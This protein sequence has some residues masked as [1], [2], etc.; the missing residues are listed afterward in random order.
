MSSRRPAALL[1]LL[2]LLLVLGACAGREEEEP[3]AQTAPVL[4]ELV[5]PEAQVGSTYSASLAASGGAAPL[6]YVIE[7][8]PPGLTY[9]ASTGALLGRATQ[10]GAFELSAK[11]V[12]ARGAQDVQAYALK[13]IASLQVTT[14]S[15]PVGQVGAA[16]RTQLAVA[17]PAQAPVQWSVVEGALPAGLALSQ[18]GVLSGTPSA[19]GTASFAVQARDAAGALGQRALLLEVRNAPA[20]GTTELKLANWNV[21]WFGDTEFGPTDEAL[22]QENVRKVIET[23]G[24]D[25]WALVEVVD[26]AAFNAL[27]AQLLGYDGFVASDARVTDGP[28]RYDNEP[29]FI[30]Q[31]PAVLFRTDRVQLE[32]A[33]LVR[34]QDYFAEDYAFAGRPPLRVDLRVGST[35]LT[36]LVVHLKAHSGST[37]SEDWARR[38]DAAALI[39]AYVDR[40]LSTRRVLVLG[41]WNDDLD[42][43]IAY[44]ATG[45]LATPSQPFIADTANYTFVTRA[46]TT[47]GVKTTVRYADPIDHQLASNELQAGYVAGSLSVFRPAIP[48]YGDNTSDHY[49][50]TS[51]FAFPAP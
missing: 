38:R 17:A 30:E 13:A 19:V 2:P 22:Q 35:D 36:L 32:S 39:K 7:G 45:Y 21:E 43:S 51:R 12:D 6:R 49:P 31:K 42:Q 11:V 29:G 18:D 3:R 47:G 41:D 37:A 48:G 50:V 46:L 26:V 1:L 33:R 25:V 27:K 28:S 14:A 24:A 15:L 16:Y 44:D 10:A 20:S 9:E 40:D 34:L 4:P 8:L 23:M 5:L